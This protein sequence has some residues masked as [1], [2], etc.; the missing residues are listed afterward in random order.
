MQCPEC[1]LTPCRTT[2]GT[3]A[4]RNFSA[5]GCGQGT[6]S[7]HRL[8]RGHRRGMACAGAGVSDLAGAGK[9]HAKWPAAAVPVGTDASPAAPASPHLPV[10][11]RA[12]RPLVDDGA[13][14]AGADQTGDRDGFGV[15]PVRSAP[16]RIT[17]LMRPLID[18][19]P[20][21][22]DAAHPNRLSLSKQTPLIQTN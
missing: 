1:S 17:S 21:V 18:R 6:K 19:D 22:D 8:V 13:G 14:I 12:L 5:S 2:T 7:G 20:V 10:L 16:K 4:R 15:D 9:F 3:F 11:T